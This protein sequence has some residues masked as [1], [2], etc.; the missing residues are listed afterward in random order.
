ML[1]ERIKNLCKPMGVLSTGEQT[2]LTKLGGIK[3]VLFDVYGT[4]LISGSGDVGTATAVDSSVALAESLAAAGFEGDLE[5]AGIRGKELLREFIEHHHHL[6]KLCSIWHPEVD[7]I[8][9]WTKVLAELHKEGLIATGVVA[10]DQIKALGVEYECRVNPTWPMPDCA[11]V[12]AKLTSSEAV[13][14][15]VSNAQFYTPLLFEAF[16]DTRVS[17][18]GFDPELCVWSCEVGEGKPSPKLFDRVLGALMIKYGIRAEETVY[19]GNDMLNDISTA[20][21]A[22]CKTVLFAGDR[23]SLRWREGDDRVAGIVPDAIITELSQLNQI[24]G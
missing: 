15:I 14:G 22:G 9:I 16:M 12:L 3:A 18:L 10:E 4:L 1:T 19:V 20:R 23:R 21:K 11:D 17:D 8:E 2:E 13:M 24:L 7:I 6:C 5:K